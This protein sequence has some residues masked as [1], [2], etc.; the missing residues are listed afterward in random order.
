M[1]GCPFN[2]TFLLTLA[3][4]LVNSF[5]LQ[6]LVAALPPKM[7]V[8]DT[9]IWASALIP[10]RLTNSAP[11]SGDVIKKLHSHCDANEEIAGELEYHG[12]EYFLSQYVSVQPYT[13]CVQSTKHVATT[14]TTVWGNMVTTHAL[15]TATTT[16]TIT[17]YTEITVHC[18]QITD[19]TVISTKLRKDIALN[20]LRTWNPMTPSTSLLLALA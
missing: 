12:G 17:G 2:I 6:S 5:A 8:S 13:R 4:V 15:V 19:L 7:K 9:F 11:L 16:K 18:P 10:A 1:A 3:F 14:T 20:F